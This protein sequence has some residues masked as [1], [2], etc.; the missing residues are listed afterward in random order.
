MGD[1]VFLDGYEGQS[2]DELI[3]LAPTHRVD[4][5]LL[6]FESALDAK[7]MQVGLDSLTRVEKTILAIESYE[8]EIN[9]GGHAQ[10]FANVPQFTAIIVESL[11]QIGCT[12]FAAVTEKAIA[13]LG[14]KDLTASI[15]TAACDD[16]TEDQEDELEACD[17]AF[18]GLN[19]TIGANLFEFI[20]DNRLS[21]SLGP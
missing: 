9:N 14:V 4:S 15:V 10:F 12:E 2:V 17:D 8:R 21:I 5:I 13:A 3:L 20:K 11:K 19:Y 1:A 6:A 7:A 18:Y 16:L